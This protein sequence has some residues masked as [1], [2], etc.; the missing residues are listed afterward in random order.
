MVDTH[1]RKHPDY[2][3]M[4]KVHAICKDLYG[5]FNFGK[6]AQLLI[7]ICEEMEIRMRQLTNFS[8]TRFAN[9]I[10]HVTMNLRADFYPVVQSLLSIE[11]DLEGKSGAQNKEKLDDARR[12]IKAINCKDFALKLSGISDL[13]DVFG[14]LANEVQT[15]DLLPHE[16]L[17]ACN[18]QIKRFQV[19]EDNMT[20]SQCL[21]NLAQKKEKCAWPRLHTDIETI[22]TD[23]TYMG[24]KV[25]RDYGDK[26][27]TSRLFTQVQERE[28]AE[29]VCDRVTE[30]LESLAKKLKTDLQ[31]GMF[32][33]EVV[34]T[35]EMIR[36]IAD[37]RALAVEVK[38]QGA[39]SVGLM[40][41]QKFAET[42]K[43]LTN[44]VDHIPTQE[45]K[46][47]YTRFLKSFETY[48]GDKDVANL[49]SKQ[50]IKD[51]LKTEDQLY[52]GHE[53]IVHCLLAVAVKYSVES[54]VESLISRYEIHFDKTRQLTP[55]TKYFGFI[56][57]IS[58][59]YQNMI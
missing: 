47:A 51:Y 17:D 16:R 44:S 41:G 36:E 26:L 57:A 50:A 22:S 46:E 43:K 3:W 11:K 30:K 38:S 56:Y 15:V 39:V 13:Y 8:T 31:E 49:D 59:F 18:A 4:T 6:N 9:S 55:G 27:R 19:M 29:S 37:L 20:H 5:K 28:N 7:D 10:R 32:S 2:E 21:Q 48:I 42:M 35:I 24:A 53:V 14:R 54:S 25:E 33:K 52:V 12:L 45:L 40:H 34:D 58:D 23:G 1:I